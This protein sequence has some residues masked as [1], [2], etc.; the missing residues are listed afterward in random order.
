MVVLGVAGTRTDYV[1]RRSY[2]WISFRADRG[3]GQTVAEG[4]GGFKEIEVLKRRSPFKL[5]LII[6]MNSSIQ[7]KCRINLT[8]VDNSSVCTRRY[9]KLNARRLRCESSKVC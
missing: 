3:L 4:Q 8:K 6:M 2:L 5:A 7:R 9:K 1:Y